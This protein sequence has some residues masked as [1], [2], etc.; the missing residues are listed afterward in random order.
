VVH[1]GVSVLRPSNWGINTSLHLE[2]P[3]VGVNVFVA[4]LEPSGCA[5]ATRVQHYHLDVSLVEIIV[6]PIGVAR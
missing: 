3:L 2:G 5:N 4:I 1:M 6:D